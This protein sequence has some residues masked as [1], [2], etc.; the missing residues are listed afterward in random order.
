MSHFLVIFDRKR[1]RDPDVERIEDASEAQERLFEMER[2]LR[3]DPE[4]GV[5]LLIA[6]REEDLSKTH[7]QYFKA[8]DDLASLSAS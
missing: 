8:V 2:V 1:R 7:G 4:R 3:H 6:E 5:V